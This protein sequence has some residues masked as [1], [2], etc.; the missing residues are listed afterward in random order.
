V[1]VACDTPEQTEATL[2]NIQGSGEC[3]CGGSVW[4]GEPVIRI[5]VCSWATTPADVDRSVA[6][7]VNAREIAQANIQ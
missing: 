3:W 6:A 4:K 1:L 5:S 7:F 2:K